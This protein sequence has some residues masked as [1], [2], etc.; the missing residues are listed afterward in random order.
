M[1][2]GAVK[3]SKTKSEKR[4]IECVWV[5]MRT[6]EVGKDEWKRLKAN[7]R[8]NEQRKILPTHL[9]VEYFVISN[10]IM[11]DAYIHDNRI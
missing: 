11:Y 9:I 8:T 6:R 7:E 4:K 1:L 3:V 10:V 2:F 5:R